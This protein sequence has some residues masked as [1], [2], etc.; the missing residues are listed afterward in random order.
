[1]Q[2]NDE[3]FLLSKNMYSENSVIIEVFT[4]N[5]GKCSGIV[6]GGTSKKIR[7]YLQVGNKLYLDLKRKNENKLGY[8]KVEIIEAI[9]P[10]MFDDKKKL[11]CLLSS[12]YILRLLLPEQF[13]YNLIYNLFSEFLFSLK[14]KENW[15]AHYVFWEIDLLKE[16][17]FDMNLKSNKDNKINKEKNTITVV[18][19]NKKINIPI[20]LIEK[21]IVNVDSKSIY[22]ALNFVGK[23]IENNILLPNNLN[24]PK[25]RKNLENCFFEY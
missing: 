6:Y 20:F 7:N 9:S 24:F 17:G 14:Y 18:I 25:A 10:F 4:L 8:F 3:G 22:L 1:M 12:I 19:D 2:W 11:L 5:H 13:K 15:I 21:K 23:F 16:I